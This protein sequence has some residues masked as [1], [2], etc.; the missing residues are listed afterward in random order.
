MSTTNFFDDYK[1]PVDYPTVP[2]DDHGWFTE[3][4]EKL[5]LPQVKDKKLVLE[6]GSWLGK[7]T[8]KWLTNSEANVICIDTWQGS[9]EHNEKRL[10]VKDKL[11]TLKDTFLNNQS[12][13]KN[14]VYPVQATTVNGLAI[15][16]EYQVSPDFIYIDADHSYESV[17]IDLTMSYSFFPN[18]FICGDDWNWHNRNQGKR[19]TVQ[20]AVKEF[21]RVNKL[22]YIN[23]HWAW[24]IER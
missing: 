15:V 9:L 11:Q 20:E 3:W 19:T 18:A 12:E 16:R 5:L 8:R 1:Y 2:K 4:N 21:C 10:D 22:K 24:Y 17:F 13:W 23:N 6:L 7:S 14:R